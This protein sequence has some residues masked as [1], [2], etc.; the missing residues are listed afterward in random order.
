[1]TANKQR[2]FIG[3]QDIAGYYQS[4]A[5]ILL[6]K[7]YKVTLFHTNLST[8]NP[9]YLKAASHLWIMRLILSV[10]S[11]LNKSKNMIVF[12]FWQIIK[13]FLTFLLM[14]WAIS[15]HDVFI[16]SY[17][18]SFIMGGFDLWFL[19]KCGKR[20]ISNIG[21]G[22]ESRPTYMDGLNFNQEGQHMSLSRIC[23]KTYFKKRK[24]K[25][26]EKYSD[27]VINAPY[28]SQ[29]NEFK[30]V[31]WFEI[32]IPVILKN[33]IIKSNIKDA[34]QILHAPTNPFI[35]GTKYIREAIK[36]LKEKGYKINYIEITGM[37]HY[38]VLE[39]LAECDF[40]IDQVF[41]DT[42]MASF[43]TEASCFG[44][45][46]IVC[47]YELE[48]LKTY[49]SGSMHPPTYTSHSDNIKEAIEYLI[50]NKDFCINLGEKAQSFVQNQWAVENVTD[51][52][53]RLINNDIP[54]FWYLNHKNIQNVLG[55]GLPKE[56]S[57]SLIKQMIDKYGVS[58]LQLGHNSDL[59]KKFVE[60]ANSEGND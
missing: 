2:I 23:I 43:P 6:E 27:V 50:V 12:T 30:Y 45:A 5:K 29:F 37:P 8:Y 42:L 17:G 53:I 16:F 11:Q 21:Y 48:K 58:S 52:Y 47:G 22:S 25:R 44:K 46:S 4:I 32:R 34:V 56:K 59:E 55:G 26:I 38:K 57:R 35:K 7:G 24:I 28:T 39:E 36:E 13:D 1:M 60:F 3:F 33:H 15:R 18:Q 41:S 14:F 51:R 40:I 54:D 20:I 10:Q 9:D 19:K 31:N 49:V